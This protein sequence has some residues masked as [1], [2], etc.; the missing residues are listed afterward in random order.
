MFFM[1]GTLGDFIY[2]IPLVVIIALIVSF[3]ELTIALP[4]H[5][6]W[7]VGG[8]KLDRASEPRRLDIESIKETFGNFL[9]RMLRWRYAVIL[10]AL[11]ML[12]SSFGYAARYMDFV[13]FPTQSANSFFVLAELPVGS[14]LD[15]TS[16]VMRKLEAMVEELPEG[17]VESYTTRL[18]G[19]GGFFQGENEHWAF[20]GVYL[21][22]FATRERN[23]DQIVEDLRNR[24]NT[25]D[26]IERTSFVIDS[27]GPPVGRPITIRVVGSDDELRPRLADRIVE[28][29]EAIEGV[30]DIDRDDKK[31]KEQI[32]VD[33]DY[34]RLADSAL[35][36]ADIARNVRLAFDGE[37]VTSVR[38]GDEDVDFRVL[39]EESARSSLDTL[40]DLIV[41]NAR[42][43]FIRLEE[44][45]EFSIDAGPSNVYHFDN[46][47]AITVTADVAK[48][49]T[50]P[51]LVT[52]KA[53]EGIDLDR[54]WPG[55]RL[56]VGGEA[57]ESAE[58]MGS[59]VVAFIAAAV[60]IY[61]LLLLLFDSTTQ[62]I[63][64]MIAIPFGLVGVIVAFAMHQQAF[65]FLAMLGVVGL[66]GIVVND[67]L[68]L[69]NLVNRL[70][71]TRPDI[72]A[73]ERIVDSTKTRLRPIVLTSITTVAGLLPM[74]YGLGGSDPFSAPMALA[75]GYGILF[76]TPITLILIPCLLA[77]TE[78]LHAFVNRLFGRQARIP[79]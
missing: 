2:V 55:M 9:E 69:V 38:Y 42:G 52:G 24:A 25:I 37:V 20:I 45:A 47:R 46:E 54:D 35:T 33:I 43:E 59:L 13:L 26:Q 56:V 71:D 28:R 31:G 8:Q 36:V 11:M 27:G 70:K 1:T 50:T 22:P 67:S 72:S 34:I 53:T 32:N 44:V 79:G 3:A 74:A 62:P 5:L 17:E 14:S 29:L 39:F 58:S 77:V 18:G 15:H 4:A 12:T 68:I 49:L 73:H 51:L 78:D 19:L 61:L 66:T 40:A 10:A 7:G 64:V 60:G 63:M 6:I 57:E 48:E 21:T 75:M 76:A 23:A 16:N 30:K 41:P 65:G